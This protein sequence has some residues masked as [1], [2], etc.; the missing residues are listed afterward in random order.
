MGQRRSCFTFQELMCGR[1]FSEGRWISFAIVE[2]C[3]FVLAAILE[4]SGETSQAQELLETFK[5]GDAYGA[6][7]GLASYYLYLGEIDKAA[8]W[9]AKAIAQRHP[10]VLAFRLWAGPQ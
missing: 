4:L 8:D 5:P 3:C 2:C 9:L 7:I 6:P 10:L 1:K